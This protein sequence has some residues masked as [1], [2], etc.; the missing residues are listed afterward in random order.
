MPKLSGKIVYLILILV[1]FGCGDEKF[2]SEQFYALGTFVSITTP[3]KQ[4][5]KIIS[6][7][8]EIVK[9]ENRVNEATSEANK[10]NIIAPEADMAELFERAKFYEELSGGR[11]SIY[12]YKISKLYGFPKGPYKIPS[13]DE[14]KQALADMK[15]DIEIDLGAYAKGW[16]VDMATDKLKKSGINSGMVNAGGDLYAIGKKS[17]RR[18]RVAIKHPD[19]EGKF[20]SIVNLE[21]IALA[22]SGDYERFFEKDGKRIHHILDAKTGKN[23]GYYNSVSVIAK[24][25]EL[26]DGLATVYFLIPEND[27]K[28]LCK[29]LKTPVLLYKNGEKKRLCGWEEFED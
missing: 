19:E 1:L 25:A 4:K 26:A 9:L 27:V 23:S 24:S 20:L 5:D 13:D 10:K 29:K 12:S 14:L 15:T 18:W 3:N 22:T 6:S 11:F 16:I 21:D 17:K 28:R 2:H 8:S 7:R